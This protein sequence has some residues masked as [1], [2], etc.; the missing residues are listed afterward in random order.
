MVAF[1]AGRV[2]VGLSV[3]LGLLGGCGDKASPGAAGTRAAPAGVA[4]VRE[5][6]GADR[7]TT[8]VTIAGKTFALEIAADAAAQDKGLGGRDQIDE[9]GGMI[10][11]FREPRWHEFVMRDCRVPIDILYLDSAG[12]VVSLYAM[13]PEPARTAEERADDP[14]GDFAYTARLRAYP[15]GEPARF[16]VEVRGGTIRKLGVEEGDVIGVDGERLVGLTE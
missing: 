2:L 4:T 13:E 12:R 1:S 7:D 10:F 3:T 8:A 14:M 6:A 11:V 16:V 15:S 9:D 5:G